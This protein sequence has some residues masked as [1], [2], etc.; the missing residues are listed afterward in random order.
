MTPSPPIKRHEVFLII[1]LLFL[2]LAGTVAPGWRVIVL[3]LLS[4]G[5]FIAASL[6]FA[7]LWND[8]DKS[9]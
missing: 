1:A 2:I 9:P 6:G 7:G 3:C 4:L 5:Y 8:K